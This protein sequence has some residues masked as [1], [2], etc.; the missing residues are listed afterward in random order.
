MAGLES[1]DAVEF[2]RP[3]HGVRSDLPF[4]TADVRYALS[5][6]QQRLAPYQTFLSSALIR[7]IERGPYAPDAPCRVSLILGYL[8]DKNLIPAPLEFVFE[9]LRLPCDCSAVTRND[10]IGRLARV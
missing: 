7:N 10:R 4:E 1:I 8:L 6:G 2:I 3:G 5:L 9:G